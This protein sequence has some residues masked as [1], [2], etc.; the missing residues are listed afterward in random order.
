[1]LLEK[2]ENFVV[3]NGARVGKVVDLKER[4]S[5]RRKVVCQR[6][7]NK[8]NVKSPSKS[9]TYPSVLVERHDESHR[10]QVREHGHR[11]GNVDDAL[12]LGDLG[13]EGAGV[14]VVRDGHTETERKDVVVLVEE[15]FIESI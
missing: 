3:G 5:E 12:V 9:K 8:C 1:M 14:Q 15:L 4:A 6:R 2:S 7:R 11:V 13:D 10:Q